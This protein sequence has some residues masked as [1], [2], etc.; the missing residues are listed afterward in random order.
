MY[1]VLVSFHYQSTPYLPT[2]Y[3]YNNILLFLHY[4]YNG[5]MIFRPWDL[6]NCCFKPTIVLQSALYYAV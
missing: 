1:S 6:L 4:G 3:V 2:Y 5:Q